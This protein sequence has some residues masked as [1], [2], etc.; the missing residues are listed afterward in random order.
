MWSTAVISILIIEVILLASFTIGKFRKFRLN[1]TALFIGS[2]FVLSYVLHL[3]PFLHSLSEPYTKSDIILGS[4]ACIRSAIKMFV[5]ESNVEAVEAFT[6]AFP[7]FSVDYALGVVIALFATISTAIEAFGD[8]IINGF[9]LKKVL[10]ESSCDI[11]IGNSPTALKYAKAC[12]AVLLLD[13]GVSKNSSKELIESGYIVLRRSITKQLFS[14]RQFNPS[15]RYNII[16]LDAEKVL[17]CIDAFIDYKKEDGKAKN[18]H[19]YVEIEGAEA[20]TVRHEIIK[21]NHMEA[22]IRTFSANELIARTFVEE[23][24]VTKFLP[25]AYI[26]NAVI[27]ENTEINVFIL[28]FGNLSRELYRQSIMNNQLVTYDGEYKTLPLNYFLCDRSI[29]PSDWEING[30]PNELREL[31]AEDHFPIPEI[32]FKT[33]VIDKLPTSREV[34]TAIRTAVQRQ[35]SYTFVIIDTEDDFQNIDLSAK[36]K[37]LL[38]GNSSYHIFVRSKASFAEDDDTVTYFGNG[39][40]VFTHDVIVND[41]LSAMAKKLNEV[42]V[43]LYANDEEG[44]RSDFDEYIKKKAEDDWNKLDHFTMYSNVYGAMNLRVKLNLLGLD[45]VKNNSGRSSLISERYVR[46]DTYTYEEYLK[47]SIRSALLAQEHARWNA[48]HLLNEY[49][50]LPKDGITVKSND[51]NKIRFNVKNADAK[52]HACITTFSGI[53]EMSSFLAEKAGNGC[54]AADYDY[55]VLDEI[56]MISAKDILN[57]LGYSATEK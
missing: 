50:P 47:P 13:D 29:D 51:G 25:D 3:I 18:L 43:K 54:T 36:L 20:A 11:V 2:V 10:K 27:K 24:P 48:Y 28:G 49:L 14:S 12:N 15:T 7:L 57:S 17:T 9:R 44:N 30:L 56:L 35:N 31:K 37:T 42:Y 6:T 53:N 21:K 19:L 41:S 8:S 23:N 1:E 38:F 46:K 5:G 26:E 45:Y 32:P 33:K 39:D 52:K 40:S 34:L 55:Y 16:C 4:L 22:Y